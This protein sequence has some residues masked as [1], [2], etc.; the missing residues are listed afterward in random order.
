MEII[1]RVQFISNQIAVMINK[2]SILIEFFHRALAYLRVGGHHQQVKLIFC[3]QKKDLK[4]GPFL[5]GPQAKTRSGKQLK[6]AEGHKEKLCTRSY[7]GD[8]GHIRSKTCL[9]SW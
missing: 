5:G 9:M 2:I 7:P 4:F 1:N 6:M 8:T 3:T